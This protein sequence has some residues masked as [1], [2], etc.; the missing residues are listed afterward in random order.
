[1]TKKPQISQKQVSEPEPKKR[2]EKVT[3]KEVY[4]VKLA[5]AKEQAK[6]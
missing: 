3:A 4:A 2:E 1:M 6:Q 5:Q